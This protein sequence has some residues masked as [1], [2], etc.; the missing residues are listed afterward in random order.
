MSAIL[1]EKP[2]EKKEEIT[3]HKNKKEADSSKDNRCRRLH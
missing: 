2:L 3:E 1:K